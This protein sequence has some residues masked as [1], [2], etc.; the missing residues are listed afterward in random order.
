MAY[1][2]KDS[3][4]YWV[5]YID[6]GGTRVRRSTETTD[7]REAEALEAKWK[8]EAHQQRQWGAPA[9]YTFDELMLKYLQAT[10]TEKRSAERDRMSAKHLYPVFTGRNLR[11]ISAANIRKYIDDRKAEGAKPATI[12]KEVGLLS[13]AIN[14][15]RME[16]DWDVPNPAAGRRL[17][18]PEGRLRWLTRAEAEALIRAAEAQSRAPHL[19]D[20]IRLALNTGCRRGEL[21]GLEWRRV[22]LQRG[23]LYLEGDHTKS[24][25][26]RYVPLN[27]AARAALLNRLRFRAKHCAASPWV[28]ASNEGARIQS[29][30]RSF[31]SACEAAG[32]E[33]FRVHDLR[34]TCAAWLVSAGVPLPEVRDLLGHSTVIM[35]E[36]YAHLAPENVRAAVQRLDGMHEN[37]GGEVIHNAE[38][39]F[40]HVPT[41]GANVEEV[42]MA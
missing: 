34:H 2:R 39:R 17:R 25:R 36:R 29:V 23:L 8:L 27:Q 14:Y 11:E 20:F 38:S 9:S 19:P 41:D 37:G 35:T 21:L 3:A 10:E 13:A 30:K 6:A 33:N 31:A 1:R 40:G 24:G 26:R 28:F 7:K 12:N 32:I 18:E 16:W 22:D 5:S 15:A 42:A 4:V